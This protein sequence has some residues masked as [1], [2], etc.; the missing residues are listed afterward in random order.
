MSPPRAVYEMTA[1]AAFYLKGSSRKAG[2]LAYISVLF[3]GSGRLH[4]LAGCGVRSICLCSSKTRYC[5]QAHFRRRNLK[6]IENAM[7]LVSKSHPKLLSYAASLQL[8]IFLLA[9]LCRLHLA[10]FLKRCRCTSFVNMAQNK[11]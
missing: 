7:I 4:Y 11:H 5:L 9:S 6:I 10:F 8:S 3:T 2:I 1:S